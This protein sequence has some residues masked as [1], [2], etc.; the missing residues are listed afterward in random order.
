MAVSDKQLAANRANAQK[1]TGPK[2]PEGKAISSRNSTRHGLCGRIVNLD[3]EDRLLYSELTERYLRDHQPETALEEQFVL[4]LIDNQWQL[5]CI[6][7][8]QSQIGGDFRAEFT[9]ELERLIKYEDRLKRSS[10]RAADDLR[11]QRKFR[12]D[13]ENHDDVVLFESIRQKTYNVKEDGHL[14]R[15]HDANGFDLQGNPAY[16]LYQRLAHSKLPSD[17]PPSPPRP[18]SGSKNDPGA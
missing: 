13:H 8:R 10:S 14:P 16:Q 5:N 3:P 17:T 9:L 15:G 1:S 4:I 7:A 2:T 11:R 18:D 12:E 6:R